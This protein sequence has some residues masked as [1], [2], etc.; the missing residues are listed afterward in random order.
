MRPP[1]SNFSRNTSDSPLQHTTSIGVAAFEAAG[2]LMSTGRHSSVRESAP[3]FRRGLS[4]LGDGAVRNPELDRPRVQ[5][6]IAVGQFPATRALGPVPVMISTLRS[7][8]SSPVFG[9]F[10]AGAFS[11]TS[12]SSAGPLPGVRSRSPLAPPVPREG[13]DVPIHAT[14]FG[15]R[16]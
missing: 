7:L 10:V 12:T 4:G 15:I 1:G 3:V 14:C 6:V 8:R 5:N 11:R 2:R 13:P 9:A 16:Q